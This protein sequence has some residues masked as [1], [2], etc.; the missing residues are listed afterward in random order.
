MEG[1]KD[2]D[3]TDAVVGCRQLLGLILDAHLV[4][5]DADLT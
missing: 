5:L 4:L 3:Q 2:V 1:K